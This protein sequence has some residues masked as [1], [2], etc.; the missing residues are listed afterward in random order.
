[1]GE[2][3]LL[4]A[5]DKHSVK[6]QAFGGMYRHQLQRIGAGPG[7]MLARFQRRVRQKRRQ[8]CVT[9]S[10]YLAIFGNLRD[11]P[12][13]RNEG[14]RRVGQFGQVLDPV[15]AFTFVLIKRSQPAGFNHMVDDFRQRQ[16]FTGAAHRFDQSHESR[17]AGA[18]LSGQRIGTGR[19]P[20]GYP[21]S[22]GNLLQLLDAAR[23]DAACR[24]IHHP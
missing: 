7:L 23:T 10:L 15:R 2:Q 5:G 13:G 3:S 11:G 19:L 8:C 22:G 9:L 20:E 4:Q 14:C 21:A 1:M 17:D 6:L 18:G 12:V 16:I 24:E